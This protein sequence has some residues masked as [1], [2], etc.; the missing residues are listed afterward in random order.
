MNFLNSRNSS[1]IMQKLEHFLNFFIY[2]ETTALFFFF[3]PSLKRAKF[4][5]TM[6]H[7]PN[8]QHF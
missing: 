6:R 2:A 4:K 5:T 8:T 1:Y 3:S 7:P